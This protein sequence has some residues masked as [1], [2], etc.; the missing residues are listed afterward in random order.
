MTKKLE[1][2]TKEELILFIENIISHI[3]KGIHEYNTAGRSAPNIS[4]K[5]QYGSGKVALIFAITPLLEYAREMDQGTDYENNK[6]FFDDI[7]KLIEDIE[8]VKHE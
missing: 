3:C 5:L 8:K 2:F 1:R 4:D 7:E 6:V